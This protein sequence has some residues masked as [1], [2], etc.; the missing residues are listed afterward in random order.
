MTYKEA[1]TIVTGILDKYDT[2][3]DEK[4]KLLADELVKYS[5]NS[6]Q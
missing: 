4:K 5:N 1:I 2:P 3:W 6:N